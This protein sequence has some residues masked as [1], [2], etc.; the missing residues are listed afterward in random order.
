M[1]VQLGVRVG[2]V[3]ETRDD[4]DA[5]RIKILISPEDNDKTDD[6]IP[7]AFPL[8]PKHFYIQPKIGEAALV[9]LSDFNNAASRRYYIGP[10]ISQLTHLFSEGYELGSDK[11]FPTTPNDYSKAPSTNPELNGVFPDKEDIAILGRK[12]C[13][14][15]LKDNDIRI[16]AGVKNVN[17]LDPTNI[18]YNDKNPAFIKLNYNQN[19][20]IKG[21]KSS[22]VIDADKI[23]L[24]SNSQNGNTNNIASDRKEL[25]SKEKLEELIEEGYKLPYGEKLVEFLLKFVEVFSQHTHNFSGLPPN[26]KFVEDINNAAT[27]PL[28]NKQMLS[29]TV[30][31]N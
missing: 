26:K 22:I 20:P 11:I 23:F 17:N 19:E 10:L 6:E 15:I 25:V 28:K 4:L 18:S 24:L 16:R 21:N 30:R 31:I 1:A 9:L 7:F 12:N 29:N 27:D 2:T 13:D 8:S 14:I 5:G 3:I